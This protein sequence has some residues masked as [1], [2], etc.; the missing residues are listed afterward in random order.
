MSPTRNS[1][2][3][4]A[5][6]LLLLPAAAPWCH[7]AS[8]R[9]LRLLTDGP[10]LRARWDIALVDMDYAIG[11][12][13]DTAHRGLLRVSDGEQETISVLSPTNRTLRIE[14]AAGEPKHPWGSFVDY[15]REG[16][17]HIWIGFDH[18]CFLVALLLPAALQRE[19]SGWRPVSSLGRA[20]G[21]IAGVVTAFTLAHSITLAMAAL[22][23][24]ELSSRW[25]ESAI[26]L[27]VLLAALNNLYPILP[28]RVW[29]IAFAGWDRSTASALRPRWGARAAG[30]Q[31]GDRSGRV[32]PGR[33]D[34]PAR[35]R[36]R[37][38]PSH[39]PG[40]L[41]HLVPSRLPARGL[42][43]HRRS[44]M[45][46]AGRAQSGARPHDTARRLS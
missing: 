32:Q 16:V 26:A 15:W 23:W 20:L 25:V 46:V 34:R 36:R 6:L 41:Q 8:D 10:D 37:T 7:S 40:P 14:S 42:R 35:H 18:I 1:P 12:D 39:L 5:L 3:I 31:S 2:H 19:G 33:R 24:V 4:L 43:R 9:Y 11:L 22:G 28:G 27:T 45:P 30:N 13:L 44:R 21:S 38:R 17:W 29:A